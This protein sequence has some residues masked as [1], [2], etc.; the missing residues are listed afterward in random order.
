MKLDDSLKSGEHKLLRHCLDNS[1]SIGSPTL[2]VLTPL[3]R[4]ANVVLTT[5]E[6]GRMQAGAL[7]AKT[8][9]R[10]PEIREL[11]LVTRWPGLATAYRQSASTD[12]LAKTTVRIQ[13]C[14][15]PCSGGY[16]P[17]PELCGRA[18]QHH[19]IRP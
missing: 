19:V 6:A 14:K 12:G 2:A 1:C 11:L 8:I 4:F 10:G 17:A 7:V 13:F 3:A 18:A 15:M 9:Y 5:T 16:W